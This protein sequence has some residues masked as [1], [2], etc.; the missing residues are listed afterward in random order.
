MPQQ[1]DRNRSAAS[2]VLQPE[3]PALGWRGLR[4][5]LALAGERLAPLLV[6]PISLLL[7]FIAAAW[8]GLPGLLE[9]SWRMGLAGLFALALVAT[10]VPLLHFRLPQPGE[11][12]DRLDRSRPEAHRPLM[13]LADRPAGTADPIALAV[14]EM[15]RA[16]ARQAVAALEAV[17]GDSRLRWRDGFALRIIAPLALVAAAFI[18]GDER[19]ARLAT[20]FDFSV[21]Q[22]APVPPRLDAWIDPPA[23]TG[24][25][26]IFLTG[27]VTLQPGEAVRA[28]VG[29]VLIVR[30]TVAPKPGASE[31]PSSSLSLAHGA[32]LEAIEGEAN[33][34]PR[35]GAQPGAQVETMRR[36][37][38]ADDVV[39]ILREG[40]E[41]AG[42]ALS[43][44]PDLA[45]KAE[46]TQVR[47]ES[48]SPER[49]NP[50]GLRLNFTLEDDY[51]I[52]K[53]EVL[54]EPLAHAGRGPAKARTLFPAPRADIPA[55]NGAGETAIATED[56]PWAGEEVSIRIRVEDDIGQEGLSEAK[57]V[58]LPQKP[59][60]HPL[61]KA[62]V[63]QRRNLV[64]WPD[65]RQDVV[66]ALDA[67]LFEPERYTPNIGEFLMLDGLRHGVRSARDDEALKEMVGRIW[68][69]AL[70]L[71]NGDMTEAERRLREAE[72]RL[73][74]ALEREAPQNEI[75][76][77]TQELRRAMEE[78]LREFAERALQDRNNQSAEDRNSSM[79]E[80][81][82]TQRD[83]Q[84]MLRR[85]EEMARSGNMAEAR[86]ML[87]ELRQLMEQLRT[88]RRQQT[89]PRMQEL[90]RQLE[91]LDR[92]Q[93]EQRDLRD[94]TFREGQQ[95]RQQGQQQ[96]G[97]RQQG[98][99]RQ[100]PGQRQQGQQGQPGE[101]DQGLQ[102]MQQAL[103]DRLRQLRERLRERGAQEGEG[104]GEAD[105][106]MGD[107]EGQLGQGQPGQATEGQQRA[108]DGLGRA[109]E[110]LAQ[111][112]QQQMGQEP[113]EGEGEG[114]GEPGPGQ[115]GRAENRTDPLGRP[116]A[117]QRRDLEDSSRVEV[118]DRDALQGSIAERAER[119]LRE[120]R[121]RLGEFERPREE[122]EY[123]ERLLRQR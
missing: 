38:K 16:R 26:P 28:P 54:M 25:P 108:L 67:L 14:W 22:P 105:Q 36:R 65:Q 32:G 117:N 78:F 96:P 61:A 49:Q 5:W 77:L 48:A 107:A 71:E 122:L 87:E 19:S 45:P 98:Q 10:L 114:P 68:E 104:F 116:Q 90:G 30:S 64:F 17:P 60:T 63:E 99:Q 1:D 58:R 34:A 123:L 4:T 47:A 83:L 6:W 56:H 112:L 81:Y 66:F 42:F 62:L 100:Q 37:I 72:A 91:E 57:T 46:L 40:R 80:R 93:R 106:G 44:I 35:A 111:Q 15:H 82:L 33:A 27:T 74:E 29:S 85:I 70:Y 79:P 23:Y 7:L 109:A 53:A 24:R 3:R 118:P 2:L 84:E 89:D 8:I 115:R 50:S 43:V 76:R 119:V 92:L 59:F 101:G 69:V 21:P 51:G 86:R 95:R 41:V 94:R 31:Q 73:R 12:A 9:P 102:D 39:R 52:A 88:A 13:T 20:A 121:R 120:L 110:G 75:R 103:R 11:V 55:R 97:Q 18:A 113:G